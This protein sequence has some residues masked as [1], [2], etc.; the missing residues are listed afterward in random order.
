[1]P[2]H[3]GLSVFGE[4]LVSREILR[5]GERVADPVPLWESLF[6]DLALVEEEQ[7]DSEGSFS[8]GWAPLADSTV[9]AKALAG[10]DPRI[11]HATLDLRKSLTEVGGPGNIHIAEPSFMVFG[12]NVTYGKYHQ[13]G[14][15]TMPRRRPVEVPMSMRSRMMKKLQR[16]IMKGEILPI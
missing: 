2:M 16:F 5:T 10:L 1:M 4:Q 15:A 12:S 13:K 3:M 6:T 11:L 7:F 8:G 14:T 9:Q